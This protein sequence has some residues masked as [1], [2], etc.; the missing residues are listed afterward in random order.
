MKNASMQAQESYQ[1]H[2]SVRKLE[3]YTKLIKKSRDKSKNEKIKQICR[4]QLSKKYRDDKLS[5]R[6][7]SAISEAIISS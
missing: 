4:I 3:K 5:F 7:S 1:L 6:I 2:R